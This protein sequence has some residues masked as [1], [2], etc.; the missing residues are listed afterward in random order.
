[1]YEEGVVLLS[2]AVEDMVWKAM[3]M[4]RVEYFVVERLRAQYEQSQILL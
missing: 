1:M 3:G 2:S 4:V